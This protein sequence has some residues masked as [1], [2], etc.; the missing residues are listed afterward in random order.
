[1][2]PADG[3]QRRDRRWRCCL[4]VRSLRSS[5]RRA[6]GARG[7]GEPSRTRVRSCRSRSSPRP[8]GSRQAPASTS[9]AV[10]NATTCSY[11]GGLL[12]I[13]VGYTAITNPAPPSSVVKVAGLPN[14]QYETYAGSK[15]SEL[16]FFKGTAA[17]GTYVVIRNYA[18][19]PQKKLVKI[20]K[21][22]YGRIGKQRHFRRHARP[23]TGRGKSMSREPSWVDGQEFRSSGR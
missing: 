17:S 6:G 16:T 22:L 9:T 19:I 12:T 11:K 7:P 2:S 20:A 10:I 21:T 8:S 5:R 3:V 23:L 1:M 13:S 18:R 4:R 15:A 14:G